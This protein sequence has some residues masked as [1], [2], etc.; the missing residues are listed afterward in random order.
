M[1]LLDKPYGYR[2][3]KA[4]LARNKQAYDL[5]TQGR[6]QPGQLYT[7]L[8]GETPLS[9]L[10][11]NPVKTSGRR[12]GCI[13]CGYDLEWA[14]P[15]LKSQPRRCLTCGQH[16]RRKHNQTQAQKQKTTKLSAEEEAAGEPEQKE[17][18]IA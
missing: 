17:E 3:T 12:S 15:Q 14:G 4:Q 6:L 5:L 16:R 1:P 13:D 18:M 11:Q 10:E 8:Y 9:P 7:T 2:R